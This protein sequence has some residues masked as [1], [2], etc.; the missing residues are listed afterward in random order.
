M[1]HVPHDDLWRRIAAHDFEVA[2]QSPDFVRRLARDKAWSVAF[3]RGAVEEYRRFA[4]LCVAGT[5]VMTPSAEVDEAWHQHLTYSRDYWDVWC[6]EVLRAPLHHDPSR[7]GP[8]QS[9]YFRERYAATLAAY[10]A[11]FGPPPEAFWPATRRRFSAVRRFRFVDRERAVVMPRL[12][13]PR[14]WRPRFPG[15]TP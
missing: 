7:G 11:R 12:W 5:E 6:A 3:A 4:Y 14:F 10:E 8:E 13:S 9:R 15:G 2:D 1:P